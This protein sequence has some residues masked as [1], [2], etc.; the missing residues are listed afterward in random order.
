LKI[1]TVNLFI[2]LQLKWL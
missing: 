1:V 2:L